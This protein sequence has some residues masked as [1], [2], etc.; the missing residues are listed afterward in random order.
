[1]P[2]TTSSPEASTNNFRSRAQ[3][4]L[5]LEAGASLTLLSPTLLL[6]PGAYLRADFPLVKSVHL[7]FGSI[8]GHR[9]SHSRLG[10]STLD[11]WLLESSVV[12]R[13]VPDDLLRL[14]LVAQWGQA[15]ADGKSDLGLDEKTQAA[16]LAI[17]RFRL[18]LRVPISKH[19]SVHA[20]AD[21]GPVLRGAVFNAGGESVFRLQSFAAE[22][23]FGLGFSP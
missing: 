6:L 11:L 16:M 12:Y 20:V 19:W 17:L 14:A 21:A 22:T 3:S 7:G 15:W 8:Y 10:R 2:R 1:M 9:T 23:S 13:P 18:S 5:T 4:G